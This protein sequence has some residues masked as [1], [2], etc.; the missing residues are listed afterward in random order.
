MA[1]RTPFTDLDDVTRLGKGRIAGTQFR[2]PSGTKAFLADGV[3]IEAIV[4]LRRNLQAR[5]RRRNRR[6]AKNRL[7]QRA[8]D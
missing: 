4:A 6:A 7:Q 3:P 5:I 2:L 8:Q 1:Q